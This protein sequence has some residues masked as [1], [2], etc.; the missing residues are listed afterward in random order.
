[1]SD[2]WLN[3][4]M[5]GDNFVSNDDPFF[6]FMET[7]QPQPPASAQPQ[8]GQSQMD[9]G[10]F[11]PQPQYTQGFD[12]TPVLGQPDIG[13]INPSA[14]L[15]QEKM[16]VNLPPSSYA[17]Q[18]SPPPF[19]DPQALI[20]LMLNER[21]EMTSFAPSAGFAEDQKALMARQRRMMNGVNPSQ[22]NQM[23]QHQGQSQG[24][25]RMQSQM[26][27]Q[28]QGQGQMGQSQN[29]GNQSH[30]NQGGQLQNP[31]QPHSQ[32]NHQSQAPNL[33][34][35]QTQTQSQA[36]RDH[37]SQTQPL[38][39]Q[40]Q[41][42]LQMQNQMQNQAPQPNLQA[43]QQQLQ[44][45][46]FRLQSSSR[47]SSV[48]QGSPIDSF[49]QAPP[50]QSPQSP[51][52][53]QMR[54]QGTPAAAPRRANQPTTQQQLQVEAFMK[55][56]HDFA[57][58]RNQPFTPAPIIGGRPVPLFVLYVL[59][60]KLG[61]LANVSRNQRWVFI[62]QKLNLPF[63][64]NPTVLRELV[65]CYQQLLASF[66]QFANTQEGQR[67]LHN[68]KQQLQMHQ[69]FREGPNAPMG[70]NPAQ[71]LA[72]MGAQN[73][74]AQMTQNPMAQNPMANSPMTQN[75][76]ANSPMNQNVNQMAP[77]S[78]SGMFQP[79]YVMSPPVKQSPVVQPSL[80]KQVHHRPSVSSTNSPKDLP[81]APRSRSNSVVP[82]RK[83]SVVRQSAAPSITHSPM[84]M[85]PSLMPASLA[86][87]LMPMA[88]SLAAIM[89]PT[90]TATAPSAPAYD[91][92]PEIARNYVPVHRQIDTYAGLDI[93]G[94]SHMGEQI[95]S[96]K[97][98]FLFAPELG[99]INLAA[100]SLSLQ[101]Y[102]DG[103]IN[104][105]LNSLLVIT[106]DQE[107]QWVLYDTP[108]FVDAL[109]SLGLRVL[110]QVV[111]A[112][113]PDSTPVTSFKA[114]ES[115]I[116]V[117]FARYATPDVNVVSIVVDSFTGEAADCD[118]TT[119]EIDEVSEPISKSESSVSLDADTFPVDPSLSSFN[120][121]P[122]LDSLHLCREEAD[123]MFSRIHTRSSTN[124]QL[125][126]IEQLIT[127]VM[128][129][130]NV[131]F[132]E[133]NSKCLAETPALLE[134]VFE[135][136]AQLAHTP[137]AFMFARRRLCLM[138]DALITLGNVAHFFQLRSH[139]DA[140][141]VLILCLS[142]GP[143]LD[144]VHELLLVP[145]SNTTVYKYQ[146]F[147]IDI[148]AKLLARDPPNRSLIAAVL[149]GI[150]PAESGAYALS[151]RYLG[152]DPRD[153]AFIA[154]MLK[155]LLS[156]VPFHSLHQ[157]TR[158][159]EVKGPVIL[160][161][162]FAAVLIV[163]MLPTESLEC[164]IALEWLQSVD[165]LGS[166][167]LRLGLILAAM[168]A[169]PAD[170]RLLVL[171]ATKS[172]ELAN[173]LLAKALEH[174]AKAVRDED[175][176][177]LAYLPRLFPPDDAYLGALLTASIDELILKR[178]QDLLA[179]VE[180]VKKLVGKTNGEQ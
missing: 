10:M 41:A 137:A 85:P 109:A 165:S 174:A 75:P 175:I 5:E 112:G 77:Q 133:A 22:M 95:D 92:E 158:M 20:N 113:E 56:V 67:E 94:L 23:N 126:R 19:E 104:T 16:P 40:N 53:N 170:N 87:A 172:L 99:Q 59:V 177:A 29:H 97:P 66:E 27:N 50:T 159:I 17:S 35:L 120:L 102:C 25:N 84:N 83:T 21:P 1:M 150:Y 180:S 103:E 86:P 48:P 144:S 70:Q 73:V 37:I 72:Q 115:A 149:T 118:M 179:Q 122:Y 9:M 135:L 141:L 178:I 43:M 14:L 171:I 28:M 105:A 55:T 163:E 164:N 13:S 98:V 134:F 153:G 132:S 36:Q 26:G 140:L 69:Q 30:I 45:Q 146:A 111:G 106:S 121:T 93:K 49:L 65:G 39:M 24:P 62:A 161:A 81:L 152:A 145:E 138:K 46:A 154:R 110:S 79:P 63:E 125:M 64:Q 124:K 51:M 4:L 142:F 34:N 143:D 119:L 147:G 156:M 71:N 96:S 74:N 155:F 108:D 101:S 15:G 76:M 11:P 91:T 173:L 58:S 128:I 107:L 2:Y 44:Q 80:I 33:V 123:A 116:D 7:N 88:P 54:A 167:L 131:S 32:I 60:M 100:L 82:T 89:A 18:Q 42:S 52:V 3:E 8:S 157:D 6:N 129:L 166:N 68:N 127:I 117:V 169:K 176:I 148:V 151:R 162:L 130:R 139:D 78:K 47:G 57:K 12:T 136:I 114:E 90:P 61:G 160:Q 168:T 31:V 38:Q